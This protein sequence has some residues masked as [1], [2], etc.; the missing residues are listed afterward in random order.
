MLTIFFLLTVKIFSF[1]I[2]ISPETKSGQLLIDSEPNTTLVEKQENEKGK[3][4]FSE[5][6]SGC[7]AVHKTDNFL[8]GVSN[9]VPDKQLLYA[10][11]RNSQEVIRSG[12]PY[13]V[14]LYEA[15]N[16]TSMTVFP[17]LSNDDI[18]DIL[19]YINAVNPR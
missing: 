2:A 8:A 18:D 10:W 7:H 5:K 9:R 1:I 12:N 14:K 6:C 13:F 3:T 16:K 17:E 15:H 11:I 4:L 19:E